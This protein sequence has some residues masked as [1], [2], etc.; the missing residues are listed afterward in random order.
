MDGNKEIRQSVQNL[1]KSVQTSKTRCKNHLQS[2]THRSTES[3]IQTA[4]QCRSMYL[5][6]S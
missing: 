6:Q 3:Y 5:L 2:L 4:L 1:E